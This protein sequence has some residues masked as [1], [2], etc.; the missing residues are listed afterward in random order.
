MNAQ[1][2]LERIVREWYEDEHIFFRRDA[3]DILTDRILANLPSLG[4]VRLD[5]VEIC[6]AELE[7]A[8]YKGITQDYKNLGLT[9]YQIRESAVKEVAH[10][11]AEAKGILRRKEGK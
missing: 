9:E 10:A 8:I 3:T 11:I 6:Q 2:E 4:F 1:K 5:D 7:R